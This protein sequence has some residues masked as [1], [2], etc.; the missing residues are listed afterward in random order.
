MISVTTENLDQDI[1]EIDETKRISIETLNDILDDNEEEEEVHA[2]E[3]KEKSKDGTGDVRFWYYCK[4]EENNAIPMS[5]KE[6]LQWKVINEMITCS[7]TE[8][9]LNEEVVLYCHFRNT[10]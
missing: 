4:L 7:K 9:D 1:S 5:M 10:L 6:E 3:F 8:W 2:N